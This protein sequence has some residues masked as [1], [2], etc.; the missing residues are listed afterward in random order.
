MSVPPEIAGT[1]RNRR[2]PHLTPPMD[3]LRK[4]PLDERGRAF[5]GQTQNEVNNKMHI[6]GEPPHVQSGERTPENHLT[7]FRGA[8]SKLTAN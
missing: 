5:L 1:S 3:R 4:T 2:T 6:V 8:A 7:S